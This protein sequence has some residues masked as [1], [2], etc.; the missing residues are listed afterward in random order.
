MIKTLIEGFL[1]G[2]STG[3]LCLLTC[4]PIYLPYLISEDRSLKK[5]FGKVLEISAGRFIAYLVF[6]AAAGWLGS[7]I[8]LQQRTLFTGISFILLSIFLILNAIRTHRAEK[9]CHV[10]SWMNITHSAFVLGIISGLNFCPSFLM[11]LTKAVD[12]GGAFAGILLF[13]GFFVGTTL[14]ILP[15]G[16]TGLLTTLGPVKKI[17]RYASI[18]IAVWFIWQGVANI[19]HLVKDP[20]AQELNA[21][22]VNPMDSTMTAF[23]FSAPQDT[24]YASALADSLALVY[25]ERPKVIVYTEL[26]PKQMY[27]DRESTILFFVS[28]LWKAEYEKDLDRNHYVVIPPGFNI[29]QAVNFLKTYDFKVSKEKGFHWTFKE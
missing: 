5:N 6:G 25:P 22:I 8:P 3:T 16:F 14:Y 18:A 21:E 9:H 10:N 2:L 27:F 17:A 12:L 11:A 28:T 24:L 23:V 13:L 15:L 20:H 26:K 4:S 19:F 29:P 1:L 7:H